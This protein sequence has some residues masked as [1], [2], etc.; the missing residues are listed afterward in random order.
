MIEIPYLDSLPREL[1]DLV[2]RVL[3]S[4]LA[5]LLIWL[6]RRAVAWV[7]ARPI[8]FLLRRSSAP[9]R[10]DMLLQ[11]I[12]GPVNLLV[13][14]LAL[15][16]ATNI[17]LPDRAMLE[18]S[19]RL[20]RSVVIVA[21]A[22]LGINAVGMFFTSGRILTNLTGIVIEEQLVPFIR[23]SIKAIIV[24]LAVVIFLQ[25]WNY[26][27]T[28]LVAGLGLAG[29]AFS[30][31]AQE[32]LADLFAFSTIV[33][34]RPFEVGEYIVTPNAE[35]FVVAIGPRSTRIRRPD[36]AYVTLPNSLIAKQHVVNWSRLTRRQ[37]N[38]VLNMANSTRSAEMRLL[39]VRLRAMLQAHELVEPETV[40]VYFNE[41]GDNA[42][43]I[44]IRCYLPVQDWVALQVEREAINLKIL[45]I[46]EGL[47][48]SIA[49]SSHSVHIESAL[50]QRPPQPT[51]APDEPA[52]PA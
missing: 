43:S 36:Q 24:A 3:L 9:D 28:G 6:L 34:D 50:P 31:A 12:Q 17:I 51:G 22:L 10:M 11:L 8:A 1:R 4:L 13:I 47:G 14:A 39:L 42:L 44:V 7:I 5:I 27:I 37:I 52:G 20:T 46:I 23:W 48:L 25:E 16:V 32:T 40:V 18:F 21:A 15:S 45:E 35:G 30:L 41:F 49:S 33:S 29:L 26:D 38:F 19:T 2:L